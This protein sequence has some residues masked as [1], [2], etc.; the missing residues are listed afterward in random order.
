MATVL[1]SGASVAGLTLAASLERYGFTVTV[2]ERNLGLR[3]GG[4]AIDVRGLDVVKSGHLTHRAGTRADHAAAV[5]NSCRA[6][7]KSSARSHTSG[8][9]SQHELIPTSSLPVSDITV[10]LRPVP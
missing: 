2:V 5:S 3:R 4:Q 6:T 1:I 8:T 7:S 10:M 9:S